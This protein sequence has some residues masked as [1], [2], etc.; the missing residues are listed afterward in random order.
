[1][2]GDEDFF[3]RLFATA[4]IVGAPLDRGGRR[5][6]VSGGALG[7]AILFAMLTAPKT[8]YSGQGGVE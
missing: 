8:Y 5:Q 1:M 2:Y 7:N 6:Y 3:R 4:H